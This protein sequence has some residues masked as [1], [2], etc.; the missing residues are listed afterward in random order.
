MLPAILFQS[1]IYLDRLPLMSSVGPPHS[2]WGRLLDS[3]FRGAKGKSPSSWVY[4]LRMSMGIWNL[5]GLGTEGIALVR[6]N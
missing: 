4:L 6:R 2:A 5:R 1:L 3:L